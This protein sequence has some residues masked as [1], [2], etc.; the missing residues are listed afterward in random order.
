MGELRA[1]PK[2]RHESD[3]EGMPKL[4]QG[5][6]YVAYSTFYHAASN[7][8]IAKKVMPV[9]EALRLVTESLLDGSCPEGFVAEFIPEKDYLTEDILENLCMQRLVLEMMLEEMVAKSQG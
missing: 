3:S 9:R 4:V 1:L 7:S 8:D 2:H 5:G 6:L